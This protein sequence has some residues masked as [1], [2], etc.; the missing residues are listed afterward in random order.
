MAQDGGTRGG[1]FHGEMG[2]CIE[3][4]EQGLLRRA[5]QLTAIDW[6]TFL[7][8]EAVVPLLSDPVAARRIHFW[9]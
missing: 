8:F 7:G 4:Q 3:S 9:F 6:P 2:H 1:T 5:L